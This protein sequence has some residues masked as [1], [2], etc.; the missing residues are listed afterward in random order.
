MGNGELF[1]NRNRRGGQVL[2]ESEESDSE[3]DL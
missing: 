3:E 1:V 2:E